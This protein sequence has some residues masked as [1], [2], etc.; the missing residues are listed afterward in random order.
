MRVLQTFIFILCCHLFSG[1]A[2]Q[3]PYDYSAFRQANPKSIL[4]LPLQNSSPEVI[5]GHSV[6]SVTTHPLA[7]SGYYVFPVAVVDETFKQNGL[8]SAAEI[9]DVSIGKLHEIFG[10]DAALYMTVSEYGAHYRII[11]SDVIVSVNARLVDLR[12]GTLLW[13]G[14]AR[15]SSAENRN[16]SNAGLAGLLIQ[17][18]VEQIANNLVDNGHIIANVASQRLLAAGRANGMLYGPR[19]PLYGKDAMPK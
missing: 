14:S 1:C 17:A 2:A 3:K 8:T 9:H 6:L 16:N 18:V 12:S 5:A 13:E 11:Q 15:A 4:I 19:S 7:E 10:A